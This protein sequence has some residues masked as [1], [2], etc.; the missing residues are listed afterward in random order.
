M[1]SPLYDLLLVLHVAAGLIGFGGCA[2]TG[3]YAA[4]GRQLLEPK[5]LDRAP[6]SKSDV[7]GAEWRRRWILVETYFRPATNWIER[8]VLLVPLFGLGMLALG[9]HR[10][11][12]Q[13]WPWIGLSLWV[14]AVG[15]ASGLLWPG[16]RRIQV[17]LHR[18]PAS[19]DLLVARSGPLSVP[20][21]P[22]GQLGGQLGGGANTKVV[23]AAC[24]AAER[25]AMVT[26]VLYVAAVAVMIA[27]PHG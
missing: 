16:E 24:R 12:D 18:S 4:L 3:Y 6:S 8:L 15:A 22:G 7:S 25:G 21:G 11:F 13:L 27:Q 23:L 2:V 17:A 19:S 1:K 14:V 9:D 26:S 5:G 20:P 10:G